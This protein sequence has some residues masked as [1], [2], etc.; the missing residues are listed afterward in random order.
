M[1]WQISS[2]HRDNRDLIF[3]YRNADRAKQL[4][5]ASKGR[6]KIV[7]DTSIYMRLRPDD[8]DDP[9]GLYKLLLGVLKVA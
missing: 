4:I 2:V 8:K 3:N 6:M 7:D 1:K 5:T 9:E